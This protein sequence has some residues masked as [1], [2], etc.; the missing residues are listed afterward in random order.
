V[1][2]RPELLQ[3]ALHRS[4]AIGPREGLHWVSPLAGEDYCEYR[5][6]AALKR[7][8]LEKRLRTPLSDFWPRRGCVWDG[9][10]IA[11]DG[12]PVL[13]EAKSH[14]AEAASPGTKASEKSRVR[15]EQSLAEAR[16]HYAP[17]STAD[18]SGVYYQYANRL[19]Y[20]FFLKQTNAIQSSLVFLYFTHDV[21]MNGPASEEEWHGSSRQIHAALGLPADLKAF[22]VYDAFVDARLLADAG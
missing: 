20:Q 9:L 8:A 3:S 13:V 16:R 2:Q 6:G 18:W 21:E 11:G 19:A 17:Q 4:G 1:N 12:R 5:D 7:L 14:L 15:I 22:G 10:G